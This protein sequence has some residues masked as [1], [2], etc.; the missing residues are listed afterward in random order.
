MLDATAM[1]IFLHLSNGTKFSHSSS[2]WIVKVSLNLIFK[3]SWLMV[4]QCHYMAG[5]ESEKWKWNLKM[6]TNKQTK[7]PRRKSIPVWLYLTS[8]GISQSI[9]NYGWKFL[10]PSLEVLKHTHY[11]VGQLPLALCITWFSQF[12]FVHVLEASS[13]RYLN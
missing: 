2:F 10:L 9:T 13:G 4:E 12:A 1:D 11:F 7:T 3:W 6:K 5:S 8:S